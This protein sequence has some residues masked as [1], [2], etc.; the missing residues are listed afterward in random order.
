M[1]LILH[2]HNQCHSDVG[3][4]NDRRIDVGSVG[5]NVGVKRPCVNRCQC[6][7]S[8]CC[9]LSVLRAALY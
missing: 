8:G 7:L 5:E 4:N 2:E 3:E 1:P 9:G 6:K